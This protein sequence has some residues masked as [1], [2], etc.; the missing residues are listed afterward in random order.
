MIADVLVDLSNFLLVAGNHIINMT[1]I[2]VNAETRGV[3]PFLPG[4]GKEPVDAVALC[5]DTTRTMV[6]G[7]EFVVSATR[8]CGA[9][10]DAHSV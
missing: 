8:I 6:L 9:G 4:Y 10:A 1:P 7:L 2:A 3:A 5:V